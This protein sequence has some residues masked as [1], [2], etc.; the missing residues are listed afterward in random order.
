MDGKY[1]MLPALS[2]S[3]HT[4]PAYASTN[5]V[6]IKGILY[7]MIRQETVISTDGRYKYALT[8]FHAGII[9]GEDILL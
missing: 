8:Y 5:Y 9:Y 7:Y 2:L 4:Q 3:Q 1:S 6:Y